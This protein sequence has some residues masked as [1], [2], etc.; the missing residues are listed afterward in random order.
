MGRVDCTRMLLDAG[1]DKNAQD[2]VRVRLSC[3]F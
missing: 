3:G 2:K 1:A